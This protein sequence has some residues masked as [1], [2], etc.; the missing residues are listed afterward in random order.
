MGH[1][2]AT[3]HRDRMRIIESIL[4]AKRSQVANG[5]NA[6]SIRIDESLARLDEL[7]LPNAVYVRPALM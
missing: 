6:S 2:S 1:Y 7:A 3:S 5:P 4:P